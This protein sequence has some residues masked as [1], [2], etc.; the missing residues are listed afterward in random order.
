M[1]L[2]VPI[3]VERGTFV[4]ES[5]GSILNLCLCSLYLHVFLLVFVFTRFL[6]LHLYCIPIQAEPDICRCASHSMSSIATLLPPTLPEQS[7]DNSCNT[8]I[9]RKQLNVL[10]LP[11]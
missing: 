8:V 1:E 6:Y 9:A 2:T 10:L 7:L 11:Y 5:K 3:Q 4:C